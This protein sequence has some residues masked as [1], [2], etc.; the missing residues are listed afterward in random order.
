MTLLDTCQKSQI[1][2]KY[3]KIVGLFFVVVVDKFIC[4]FCFVFRVQIKGGR[5]KSAEARGILLF[6]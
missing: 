1:R 6:Q 5:E 3:Q 4:F 2:R